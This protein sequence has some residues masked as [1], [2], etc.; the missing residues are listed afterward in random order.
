MNDFD[1]DGVQDA[2]EPGVPNVTVRLSDCL[3]NPLATQVTDADGKYLFG[4]LKPGQ[5]KVTFVLPAGFTFTLTDIGDDAL[6]SDAN[7]NT[8]MTGCY[9]LAPG[10]TN[11]TVDAGL[12]QTIQMGAGGC[13]V[14]G[15]S[16]HQT[17]NAGCV[18]ATEPRLTLVMADKGAPSRSGHRLCPTARI[19]AAVAASP[20]VRQQS[21]GQLPAPQRAR[22]QSL[23]ACLPCPRIPIHPVR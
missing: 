17:N 23:N 20:P 16:N 4:D 9:A 21:G 10:E 19:G 14:T 18:V 13:R 5:Y 15:G 8:G 11:L 6:D 3:G 1:Q 12:V 2:S 7:Q 22:H